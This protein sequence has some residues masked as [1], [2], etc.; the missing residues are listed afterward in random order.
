MRPDLLEH[1]IDLPPELLYT[2]GLAPAVRLVASGIE[3][4]DGQLELVIRAC[5]RAVTR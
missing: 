4:D 3:L 2:L 1:L 5:W